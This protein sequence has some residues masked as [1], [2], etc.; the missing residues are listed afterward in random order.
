MFPVHAPAAMG[1]EAGQGGGGGST[2]GRFQG[3]PRRAA[4]HRGHRCQEVQASQEEV[5][6]RG[7]RYGEVQVGEAQTLKR[8]GQQGGNDG[9]QV[10]GDR[11]IV[12]WKA[13]GVQAP[14]GSR[15]QVGG[16]PVWG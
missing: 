16:K 5:G 9:G 8:G 12:G 4:R 7:Q 13:W 3:W 14:G 11:G 10:P 1:R 6:A 15:Q 2:Q